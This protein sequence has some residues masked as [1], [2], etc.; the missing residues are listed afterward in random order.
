MDDLTELK[1]ETVAMMT[2]VIIDLSIEE[3][4]WDSNEGEFKHVVI[5]LAAK[6]FTNLE[7]GEAESKRMVIE[8]PP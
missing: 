2:P 7:L 8:L 1:V 6:E 5:D 4:Q 3:E